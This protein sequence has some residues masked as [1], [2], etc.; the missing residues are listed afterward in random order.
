MRS[1]RNHQQPVV[2]TGLRVVTVRGSGLQ[3]LWKAL[4]AGELGIRKIA[5][6]GATEF[7]CQFARQIPDFVPGQYM[8]HK[9]ARRMSRASRPFD[10]DWEGL[11]FSDGLGGQN[12]CLALRRA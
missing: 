8:C 12:A 3:I 6:F 4:L 5:Q 7:S 9:D 1:S 2:L 11:V 10:S